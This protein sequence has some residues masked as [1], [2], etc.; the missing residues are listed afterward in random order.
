MLEFLVG[1]M[2]YAFWLALFI[3][4]VVLYGMRIIY[5]YREKKSVIDTLKILFLPFSYGY[6]SKNIKGGIFDILYKVFMVIMFLS[7]GI[8]AVMVFYTHFA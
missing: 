8:G 5:A 3:N 1:L 7:I 4:F 6:L 2:L